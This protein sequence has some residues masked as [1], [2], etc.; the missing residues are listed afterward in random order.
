MVEDVFS[1]AAAHNF[2]VLRTWAFLDIGYPDGSQSVGGGA[3]NGV[4][5]QAL[6]PATRTVVYNESGLRHLD[7]VL[8]TAARYNVKLILTLT[9]NWVDFGGMDQYV[10]WEALA[11]A[12]YAAEGPQ[13]D[14]FYARPWQ[15]AAYAAYVSHVASRTNSITGVAY[16]DDP[17]IFAWELANEPRCQGSG[18]YSS[19]N[20]CTLNYAKYHVQPIAWKI[21]P[22]VAFASA[23]LKAAD[24]NHLVAVGDEGFF[25]DTY[26]DF[27]DMTGDCYV[28]T[29]FA[30]FTAIPTVDFGSAHLYPDAW[31]GGKGVA[32]GI[33][34][35]R[36][37]TAVAHALG[38]PM[39]LGE[40]GL[41]DGQAADY[42][43]WGAAWLDAGLNGDAFWMLC[44]RQDYAQPW[45]PNYDG[46]CVYCPNAS[47][48][49]P[50][51]GDPNSCAALTAHANAMRGA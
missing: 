33:E 17:T 42:A 47:D 3:K 4:W 13:H 29:D 10:R 20:N 15:R 27:P 34:W 19:S 51:S 9:N 32:W 37:H 11:N 36:N 23:T 6:D 44:G 30:A 24:P 38:K 8:A 12:S 49:A 50:P 22:W 39:L 16:R 40:F 26:Q 7:A 28:G 25:C 45:Y 18:A 48:P 41:K 31:G 14:D 2:T 35:V 43:Q 21:T 1:R 46:F 5:F